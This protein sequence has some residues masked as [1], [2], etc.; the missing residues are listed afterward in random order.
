[1]AGI[2]NKSTLLPE[3]QE[4]F[5]RWARHLYGLVGDKPA[6]IVQ[7]PRKRSRRRRKSSTT[8]SNFEQSA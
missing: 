2:H 5:A 4:A 8:R 1:V 3:R 6:K 7:M